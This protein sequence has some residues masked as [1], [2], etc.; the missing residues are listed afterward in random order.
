[1]SHA[2]IVQCPACATGYLL[3]R[4]LLGSLGARV[5]CPACRA[6]FDVDAE[7]TLDAEGPAGDPVRP[8]VPGVG[9]QADERAVAAEV[10]DALASRAGATLERAARENRLFR[11][12]GPELLEAFDEYRRRAGE[13]ATAQAFREELRR[14]WQVE[15]FPLAEARG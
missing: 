7:G 12:H 13:R 2:V 4:S 8:F 9:P 11:S 5:T 1:V 6:A 14:R 3:P 10:L 15:L